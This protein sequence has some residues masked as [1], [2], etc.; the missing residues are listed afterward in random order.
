[1]SVRDWDPSCAT[2][3]PSIDAQHVALFDAAKG[4]HKAFRS[5]R[6]REAVPGLLRDL[7]AYCLSHFQD[8]EA[9]MARLGFPDLRAHQEEHRRL[10]ARVYDL[11]ERFQNGEAHAAME[12]SILV[13]EWLKS[14]IKELDRS[15]ADYVRSGIA[16]SL[17]ED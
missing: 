16:P 1:M 10:M 15:F 7:E 13:S 3:I 8:E 5:G 17:P 14:H 2:G 9:H 12:V 11:H 4:L 6:G